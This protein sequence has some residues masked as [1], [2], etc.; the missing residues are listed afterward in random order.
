MKHILI[1]KDVILKNHKRSTKWLDIIASNVAYLLL[2]I[3]LLMNT[4]SGN[5]S[6]PFAKNSFKYL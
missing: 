3:M 1:F 2:V 4:L 6:S 5:N